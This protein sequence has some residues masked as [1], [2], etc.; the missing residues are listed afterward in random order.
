MKS[1]LRLAVKGIDK[2]ER[3][4]RIAQEKTKRLKLEEEH[5]KALMEAGLDNTKAMAKGKAK[6]SS[7]RRKATSDADS[8]GGA[9]KKTRK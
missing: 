2:R 5:Q 9:R 6:A 3:E 1:K 8:G 7:K 4:T